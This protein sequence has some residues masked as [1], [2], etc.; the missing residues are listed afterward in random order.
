MLKCLQWTAFAA[1][2]L[3]TLLT[4]CTNPIPIAET[5]G[6]PSPS[7]SPSPTDTPGPSPAPVSSEPSPLTSMSPTPPVSETPAATQ[8]IETKLSSLVGAATGLSVQ[9][10][11]CPTDMAVK[12]GNQFDCQAIA[13]GESFAIAVTLINEIGPEFTWTTKGL[14]QMTKLEQFIQDRIK[15]KSGALVTVNC[16]RKTRNA[17]PND[18]FVCQITDT[19][20]KSRDAKVTVKDT[21]G[22]VDIAI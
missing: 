1:I 20:G 14:L 19:Q 4:S 7:P 6:S 18:T 8:M 15:A 11:S 3:T 22:N 12:A 5:P 13:E 10:V 2:A 21:Q 9:S 17:N 16:G